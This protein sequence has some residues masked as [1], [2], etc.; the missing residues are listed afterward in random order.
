[1]A[2]ALFLL[3]GSAATARPSDGGTVLVFGDSLAKG[4]GTVLRAQGWHVADHA[5]VGWGLGRDDGGD[6]D[7]AGELAAA[8]KDASVAI[9]SIG[10]NDGPRPDYEGRLEHLREAV[11][12]GV[13]VVWLVP[14]KGCV[15]EKPL[16]HDTLGP[17]VSKVAHR[18]RD[19]V[20]DWSPCDAENR[21]DDGIHYSVGGYRK[22]TDMLVR[23]ATR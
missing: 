20:V 2:C 23:A 12:P 21:Q 14:P 17:V 10:T 13:D 16:S 6:R 1:M 4:V 19:P 7:H 22:V 8:A 18:W 9:I 15:A 3:V 5:T 11:A